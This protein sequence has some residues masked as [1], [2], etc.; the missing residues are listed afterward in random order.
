MKYRYLLYNRIELLFDHSSCALY[1]YGDKLDVLGGK[2]FF[3]FSDLQVLKDR[4]AWLE[5][6]NR[7]LSRELHEYHSRCGVTLQD[8]IDAEVCNRNSN[9][10]S[11]LLF[12]F[13]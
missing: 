10:L 2:M 6:A 7:D 13:S 1:A 9:S 11:S 12:L 8:E 3:F 4:I 5:A